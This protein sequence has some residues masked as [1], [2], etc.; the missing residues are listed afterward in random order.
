MMMMMMLSSSLWA[1]E[2]YSSFYYEMMLSNT[3]YFIV[4]AMRYQELDKKLYYR[5]IILVH[6]SAG[7][8]ISCVLLYTIGCISL[9]NVRK[10]YIYCSKWIF[11]IYFY[12]SDLTGKS[13]RYF[14]RLTL[15][16]NAKSHQKRVF[17]KSVNIDWIKTM[18]VQYRVW[19]DLIKKKPEFLSSLSYESL[20]LCFL[21]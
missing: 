20:R 5:G 11:Y 14:L 17:L 2:I 16:R 19:V 1:M 3:L 8:P 10:K 4:R 12:T 7:V 15:E 18:R 13:C 9:V 21:G 6:C